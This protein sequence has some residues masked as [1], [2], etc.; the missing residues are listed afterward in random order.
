LTLASTAVEP[1]DSS[2]VQWPTVSLGIDSAATAGA[3]TWATPLNTSAIVSATAEER[4][5]R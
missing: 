2:N 3:V 4:L 5:D 1:L